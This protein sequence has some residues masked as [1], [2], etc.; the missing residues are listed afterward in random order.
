MGSISPIGTSFEA[1]ICEAAGTA[2]RYCGLQPRG[3]HDRAISGSVEDPTRRFSFE[4]LGKLAKAGAKLVDDA[5]SAIE[6]YPEVA[7]A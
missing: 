2:D 1:F 5:I 7:R 6:A 3:S 4:T